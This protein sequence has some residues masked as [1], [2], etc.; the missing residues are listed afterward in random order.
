MKTS[1]YLDALNHGDNPIP[2]AC[3][4]GNVLASGA[5]FG[6]DP[7]TGELAPSVDLQCALIFDH[8]AALLEQ[9]RL[10]LDNVVK[11]NFRVAAHVDRAVIN[12]RWVTTFPDA[13]VRPARQIAIADNLPAGMHIQA[14]ILA[15]RD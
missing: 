10:S 6:M 11:I 3:M 4:V 7:T 1:I 15:V 12:R 9:A 8:L 14:D 13:S 5:L 2:A